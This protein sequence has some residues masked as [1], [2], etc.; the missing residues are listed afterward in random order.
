MINQ[1]MTIWRSKY[2]K[3]FVALVAIVVVAAAAFLMAY[4]ASTL[5]IGELDLGY[6]AQKGKEAQTLADGCVAEALQRIKL[7]T[8]YQEG[9]IFTNNGSC[10]IEVSGAGASRSVEVEAVVEGKF[11]R[12][13]SVELVLSAAEYPQITVTNWSEGM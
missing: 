4:S 10:T 13:V 9:E 11:H 1:P 7:D 12:H 3:G 5:G 2:K 8:N 6:T